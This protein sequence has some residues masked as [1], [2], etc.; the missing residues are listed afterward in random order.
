MILLDRKQKCES[1]LIRNCIEICYSDRCRGFKPASSIAIRYDNAMW[2][3]SLN[4]SD[5]CRVESSDRLGFINEGHHGALGYQFQLSGV[6]NWWAVEP[7]NVTMLPTIGDVVAFDTLSFPYAFALTA[8]YDTG[9]PNTGL[10]LLFY[11]CVEYC[12][13]MLLLWSTRSLAVA[14]ARNS[15]RPFPGIAVVSM[16]LKSASDSCQ[17]F[18]RSLSFLS[19]FFRRALIFTVF[20]G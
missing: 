5:C 20:C 2:Q 9:R 8:A 16:S 10:W 4:G 11:D 18:M 13:R 3:I 15:Y 12:R 17:R 6:G 1:K 7:F 14:D 19:T